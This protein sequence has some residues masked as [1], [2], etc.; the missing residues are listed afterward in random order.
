[1]PAGWPESFTANYLVP[2]DNPF[3]NPD[4]SVL[5]EYYAMEASVSLI[6]SRALR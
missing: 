6:A 4:G 1:M 2:N 5:E 3:V